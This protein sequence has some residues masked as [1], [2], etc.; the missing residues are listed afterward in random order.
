ME[1]DFPKFWQMVTAQV[2]HYFRNVNFPD[3]YRSFSIRQKNII[4]LKINFY[5][6][7]ESKKNLDVFLII[8]N[9]KKDCSVSSTSE[10]ITE[11]QIAVETELTTISQNKSMGLKG[12]NKELPETIRNHFLIS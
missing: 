6:E 12:S 1:T 5:T 8:I 10:V 2:F 4:I 3:I 11:S 7:G 9:S